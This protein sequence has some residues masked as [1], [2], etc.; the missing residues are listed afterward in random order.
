MVHEHR[1]ELKLKADLSP[2]ILNIYI[3]AKHFVHKFPWEN[4]SLNQVALFAR[5]LTNRFPL[6]ASVEVV[7]K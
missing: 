1:L 5:E 6:A 4:L 2:K 3:L 7:R